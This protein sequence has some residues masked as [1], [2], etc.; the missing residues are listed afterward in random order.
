MSNKGKINAYL[1]GR[2]GAKVGPDGGIV[3]TQPPATRHRI[4][5]IDRDDGITPFMIRCRH[6]RCKQRAYSQMYAV[7][8]KLK[9][10]YE[11]YRPDADEIAELDKAT[12]THVERGGLLLREIVHE[13]VTP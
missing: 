2:L 7:D 3:I 13:P 8:Q 1:C 10:T 11:W 12:R 6:P 9:P 5:T 4:V